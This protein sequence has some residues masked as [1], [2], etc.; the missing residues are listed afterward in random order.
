ML[1][2]TLLKEQVEEYLKREI[3]TGKLRPGERID[4]AKYATHWGVS[5][6]PIRFAVNQLA[7]SG[8]VKVNPRKNVT[9][10][11]LDDQT[12]RDVMDLRM[13]LECLAIET[14]VSRIS[15]KEIESGIALYE[16]A[17]AFYR[18]TGDTKQLVEVDRL[19]HD[20]IV[21]NSGNRK[22]IE[23][24]NDL[25]DLIIWARST[26]VT[27]SP[28]SFIEALPEHLEIMY[29]IQRQDITAAQAALRLHLKNSI[30]R[31]KAN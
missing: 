21:S 8:F 16:Q 31:T 5:M 18:E 27:R 7:K 24:M 23:I 19:V 29:A 30:S 12:F 20:L 14:A 25:S 13:S 1:Q 2:T 4:I 15:A 6:T 28:N 26:V 17:G 10:A 11:R 9:V 22:L 3:V